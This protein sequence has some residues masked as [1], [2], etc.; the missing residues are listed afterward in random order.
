MSEE[1]KKGKR[2]RGQIIRSG[3]HGGVVVTREA[4]EGMLE[5]LRES[6]KPMN[7]EHDPTVPP[8]GR[9][10]D[11]RLVEVED[12]EVAL[13]TEME[14]FEGTMP[15]VLKP[16][17]EFQ[18]EIAR[19]PG[20]PTADGVLEITTDARSY[21]RADIEALR[22]IAAGVGEAE[23]DDNAMRFSEL[24]D[25]LLI[26]GLGSSLTAAG[27]FMKGF[28]T[29]AGEALGEEV[30][31]DLAEAYRKLKKQA[32]ETIEHRKPADRP[33]ITL[34]TFRIDRPG[35]GSVEIEGSTRAVGAGLE[36]LLD[37]GSQLLPIATVYLRAAPQPGRVVK[38]HFAHTEE[39]WAFVYGLDEKAL[40]LMIAGLTDED[41]AR[42]LAE[43]EA[44]APQE[45]SGG[46]SAE[47]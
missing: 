8:V 25:P 24:P 27:W 15:A 34:L 2:Y 32:V 46:E 3:E 41:Y 19:L 20:W 28:F 44:K 47:A 11:G 42:A 4:V 33:P 17:R 6:P 31:K 35:G 43:A 10:K 39:G 7:I 12:G 1:E 18:E 40:P 16:T 36:A 29:K 21:S 5:Q 30:G 26:F 13:E 45:D 22:D 14:I 23:A 9:M 38:M 37:A